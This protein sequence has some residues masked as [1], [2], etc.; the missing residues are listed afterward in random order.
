MSGTMMYDELTINSLIDHAARFHGKTEIVSV[1]TTGGVDRSEW[2]SIGGNARRLGAALDGLGVAADARVGTIAWNNRRHLEIYF[3]AAG[4]GRVTHT[5]NPRLTPEQL[6]YIVN[7]AADEVLMFDATFLPLI[8]A[9]RTH[10]DSVRHLVL[11]GPRD[12]DA[13]SHIPGLLFYDELL[14]EA[15]PG[16][17]WPHIDE[18]RPAA[19]CY[20]SGTTGNPKGV[21]YTHRSIVLHSIAGNQPDGLGV[22]ARDTVMPVVP[23]F[24][25]NAWGVPYIAAQAGARLVLPGPNLDGE[26][27]ALL[28]DAER[29]TISLGV[30][31]IWMGLL[32]G[33]KKTG[34]TAESMTRTVVGGAA[35]PPSMIPAFRDGYGVELIHAW[36]MTETSPLGTLNHLLQ[37]HEAL[38][39]E[40]RAEIRLGQGRPPWGVDL[41]IV[42]E[43][44]AVLP[45]DGETQGHL[46]IRGHW[47][48]ESYFNRDETAL[49]DDGW[50][51]TGDIA[52][53]D[54]DGY[55]VIRDRAKD[56]IKS[57]GEWIST[58]ELENIAIAHPGIT[59]AA[60][61]GA[62]HQK[63]GERPVLLA[64]AEKEAPPDEAD[65]R[66]FYKGK[67]AS[68]QVPDRIIFVDE[69][70]IGATGKV[71][72][73]KLR[74]AYGDVLI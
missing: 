24:H 58:V 49:T 2:A 14:A 62:R 50:F 59:N 46:Q 69:L 21:Q 23:M 57:G 34:A 68:W 15:D 19:M 4:S 5:I 48:V 7:H 72:K 71:L 18:N 55:M 38:S 74:E 35:L 16:W 41:R 11:M 60:A 22:S 31:T 73:A 54:P 66:E 53:I 20:T 39:P 33:L 47:I 70:P 28:I 37:K 3:G 32:A 12:S 64:V 36:G 63:W 17:Q 67:V 44:G 43:D 26:S 51:E 30:P 25:V 61:I 6:A 56:I 52:T 65:I 45:H 40:E 29:V 9:L 13:A 10:L 42:D 1:E 8:G 27:L